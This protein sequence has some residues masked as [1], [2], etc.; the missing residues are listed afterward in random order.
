MATY[1]VEK[2]AYGITEESL[3][4]LDQHLY[5]I[6]Q[7]KR[8]EGFL[9]GNTVSEPGNEQWVAFEGILGDRIVVSGF[10]WGYR[11]EGPYGL[12]RAAKRGGLEVEMG[13]IARL[14]WDRG[15]VWEV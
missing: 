8:I 7:V 14:P 4:F 2:E 5:Q 6:G 13:K 11:G 9:A 12:Q 15:F 1:Y 10:S 3:K